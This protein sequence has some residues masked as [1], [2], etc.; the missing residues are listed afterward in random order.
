[1]FLIEKLRD[2]HFEN[3]EIIVSAQTILKFGS[4]PDTSFLL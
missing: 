4:D 1:M 3:S 2:Y